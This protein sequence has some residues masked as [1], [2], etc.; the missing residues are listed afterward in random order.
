M[1]MGIIGGGGIS[2]PASTVDN[3]IVR[4]DGT[5]GSTI[6]DSLAIITDDGDI[7]TTGGNAR[8]TNAVDLQSQR[9]ADAKVASG[10]EAVISGGANNTASNLNCTICGGTG[11]TASGSYATVTGGVFNEA[12]GSTTV[13]TGG[14]TNA[15]NSELAAVVGGSN[16]SALA[17][18]AIVVGGS[19]GLADHNGERVF[20]SRG[21]VSGGDQ[22]GVIICA[23]Q[24]TDAS[25]TE[26]F[27]SGDSGARFTVS[28]DTAYSISWLCFA[29]TSGGTDIGDW[30][31][32][33]TIAY[34][35][36]S[37]NITLTAPLAANNPVDGV[38]AS[39]A[40]WALDISA[41]TGNQSVKIEVTGA[42]SKTIN[43]RV[44]L[45]YDK[46]IFA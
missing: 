19:Y 39:Y 25:K 11:N 20:S 45:Q 36:G 42:A 34:R 44:I 8:G 22:S 21:S 9:D 29:M 17:P 3:K 24:T 6:Q 28:A 5:G 37:G 14:T 27:C 30:T 15:A 13:I 7:Q 33:A 32:N 12:S 40:A 10:T 4:M 1:G 26:I 23:G 35:Q 46:Q 16:N 38:G 41:D 2:G 43:W 18:V 31:N